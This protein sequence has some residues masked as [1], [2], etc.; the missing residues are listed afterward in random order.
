MKWLKYSHNLQ[1]EKCYSKEEEDS[2]IFWVEKQYIVNFILKK[3]SN[4]S[5]NSVKRV[6]VVGAFSR[7]IMD[8]SW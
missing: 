7:G 5:A 4:I 6:Y 1:S 2:I 8:I 3:R